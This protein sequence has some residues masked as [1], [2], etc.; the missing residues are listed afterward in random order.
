MDRIRGRDIKKYIRTNLPFF[1]RRRWRNAIN[2]ARLV[3]YDLCSALPLYAPHSGGKYIDRARMTLATAEHIF[4]VFS[5]FAAKRLASSL[6]EL[7][8]VATFEDRSQRGKENTEKLRSLLTDYGS[9]KATTHDY[10]LFYASLFKD[11]LTVTSVFE[12]GLGT[13]NTHVISNMGRF[14]K[15]GASLRAFRDYFANAKIEGADIDR[16]VLFQESRIH[17]HWVDQTAAESFLDLNIPEDSI[18]LVIDDGL[19]SPDANLTT[20]SYFLNKIKVEGW[21]IIEDIAPE[22]LPFWQAV[23]PLMAPDF[24]VHIIEARRAL[25]FAVKRLQ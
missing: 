14:G 18:D 3:N 22:A 24:E 4:P 17:T 12:V 21:V 10:H 9:D 6:P 7:A 23:A 16:D 15:P 5:K 19:H 20:L 8:S 11:P 25:M 2:S 1:S 13:N